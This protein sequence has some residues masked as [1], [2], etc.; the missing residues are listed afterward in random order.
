L[1]CYNQQNSFT[2]SS[3]NPEILKDYSLHIILNT[4]YQTKAS[5]MKQSDLRDMFQKASNTAF[6]STAVVSPHFLSD[7]DDPEPAN[8]GDIHM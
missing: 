2:P 5:S 1:T 3:D 8:E 7:P 6:I 4:F